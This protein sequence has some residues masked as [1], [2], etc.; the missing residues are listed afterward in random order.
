MEKGTGMGAGGWGWGWGW[1][2]GVGGRRERGSVGGR[3]SSGPGH[4]PSPLR[5]GL[6][7]LRPYPG[8]PGHYPGRVILTRVS[9]S[10]LSSLLSSFSRA[11][12]ALS[13]QRGREAE[14]QRG[15]EAE[16]P[17]GA[18]RAREL[19]P[20]LLHS[21]A[22]CPPRPRE[23]S[24]PRLR[25]VVFPGLGRAGPGSGRA[26]VVPG[27]AGLMVFP[28]LGRAGLVFRAWAGPGLCSGPGPG[29][30]VFRVQPAEG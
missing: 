2:W 16:R 25:L 1:G 21:A 20:T 19:H 27:L 9:S 7:T 17:S 15:R 8:G 29:R 4:S 10:L 26:C 11:D 13:R 3:M 30:V 18:A 23:G 22:S 14:W 6:A 28:C 5:A 24:L 12:R